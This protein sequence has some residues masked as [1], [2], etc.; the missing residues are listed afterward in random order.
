MV[1][2]VFHSGTLEEKAPDESPPDQYVY[3][4]PDVRPAE[5]E[6]EEV[7]AYLTDQR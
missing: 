2:D 4:P 1:N 7:K 6:Q 5:L 3:H